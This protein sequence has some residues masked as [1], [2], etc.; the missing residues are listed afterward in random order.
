MRPKTQYAKCGDI[1]IAFQVS[2][3]GPVD[4]I[5]VTGW[6]SNLDYALEYPGYARVFE[7]ISSFARLIRFDKRG[8]GLSDRG[9]GFPTLEQ[10]ME[11]VR[12]VMDAAGSERAYLLGTSEGGN[13]SVLFAAT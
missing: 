12:A 3:D 9:V 11:D 1:S 13:M 7:R 6:I 8:T 10:R 2:G 5:Y 4:V